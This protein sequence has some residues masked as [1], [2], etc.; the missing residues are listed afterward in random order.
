MMM[1]RARW[2]AQ[3]GY[4]DGTPEADEAWAAKLAFVPQRLNTLVV[5]DIAPYRAVGTDIATGDRPVISS[6]SQH[7]DYLKRNGFVELGNEMPKPAK[8]EHSSP[9]EIGRQIKSVMDQ[10][11]IRA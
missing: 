4:Q 10:K 8:I 6:R 2:L 5:S 7:R 1:D 3:W 9:A 11:G